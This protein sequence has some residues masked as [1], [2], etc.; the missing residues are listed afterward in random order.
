MT[1]KKIR[2]SQSKAA[3]IFVIMNMVLIA[4]NLL[5]IYIVQT[6]KS[7]SIF[8]LGCSSIF[9]IFKDAIQLLF[10]RDFGCLLEEDSYF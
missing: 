4:F 5:F 3:R 1:V 6:K 2:Q 9:L 10:F 7:I 8:G